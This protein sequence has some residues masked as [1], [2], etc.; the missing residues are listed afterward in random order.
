MCSAAYAFGP[1]RVVGATNAD[2]PRKPRV[3]RK[4][5]EVAASGDVRTMTSHDGRP[6]LVVGASDASGCREV[7][8]H[9]LAGAQQACREDRA[10]PA[11]P[12]EPA[13][14]PVEDGNI[15]QF[16]IASACKTFTRALGN[17]PQAG[18]PLEK[19]AGLSGPLPI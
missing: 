14:Y 19:G 13:Q 8:H 1:G 18:I 4:W 7:S 9:G 12:P 15:V 17:R 5:D 2:P 3:Q 10:R 16:R 6:Q 11:H